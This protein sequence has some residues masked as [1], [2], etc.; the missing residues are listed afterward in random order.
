MYIYIFILYIYIYMYI[1]PSERELYRGSAQELTMN[2]AGKK[3][4]WMCMRAYIYVCMSIFKY[5]ITQ[6][7]IHVILRYA[8]HLRLTVVWMKKSAIGT[9]KYSSL[10]RFLY[11][12]AAE[13]T[14]CFF[15][16]S[17]FFFYIFHSSIT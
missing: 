12:P 7:H 4:L 14:C 9:E 3:V 13:V 1:I 16:S 5:D 17:Y 10:A 11:C 6:W 15:S 2:Q 8:S